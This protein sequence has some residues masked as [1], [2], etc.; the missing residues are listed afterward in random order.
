MD[1][2]HFELPSVLDLKAANPLVEN[3]LALRGSDLL[4]GAAKVERIGGQC[5]QALVSAAAT[6][7]S[8]GFSLEFANPSPAFAE[9]LSVLGMRLDDLQTTSHVPAAKK[10]SAA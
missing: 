4:I 10:S 2:K 5:L 6:W 3:L 7:S 8:D 9:A 1:T